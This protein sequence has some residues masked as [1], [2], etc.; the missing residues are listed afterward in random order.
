MVIPI[1]YSEKLGYRIEYS[2]FTKLDK[3]D[4]G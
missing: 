3:V 1:S 2:I 4:F